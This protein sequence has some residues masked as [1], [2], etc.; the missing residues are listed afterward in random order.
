[1]AIQDSIQVSIQKWNFFWNSKQEIYSKD[2][3]TSYSNTSLYRSFPFDMS[4]IV[5]THLTVSS[6]NNK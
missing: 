3:C 1:M 2:L 5:I 6:S 4:I